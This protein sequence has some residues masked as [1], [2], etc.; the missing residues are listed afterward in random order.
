MTKVMSH[1]FWGKRRGNS[2]SL[3]GWPCSPALTLAAP[4]SPPFGLWELYHQF[5]RFS[6][7]WELYDWLSWFSSL[8]M[9]DSGFQASITMWANFYYK[10]LLIYIYPSI[11]L[12]L[13]LFLWTPIKALLTKCFW[14]VEPHKTIKPAKQNKRPGNNLTSLSIVS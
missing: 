4:S 14:C 8:K 2:F 1:N 5:P 3:L 7:L 6:G 10:F 9:V 13:V 12:L 11:H